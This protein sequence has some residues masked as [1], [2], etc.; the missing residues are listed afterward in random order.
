MRDAG[1]AVDILIVEDDGDIREALTEVLSEEGYRVASVVHGAAA[2]AWLRARAA[3]RLI[4]L[5]LMM[6]V[7]NGWEFRETQ[8]RDERLSAIPV[9]VVSADGGAR[10]A[11]RQFDAGFLPK[12]VDLDSLLDV[13]ARFCVP[14]AS[15]VPA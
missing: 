9:V 12:P 10:E 4:L 7:M 13:V 5:D 8:R 3:P 2:L 15:G 6:P 11:A 14:L 1:D